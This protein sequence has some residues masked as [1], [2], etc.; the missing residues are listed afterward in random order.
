MWFRILTVDL[1]FNVGVVDTHVVILQNLW[2]LGSSYSIVYTHTLKKT[3]KHIVKVI[4]EFW[5]R[6]YIKF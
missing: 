2:V 4:A 3:C 5:V 1:E 6:I